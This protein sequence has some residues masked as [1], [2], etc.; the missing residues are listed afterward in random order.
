MSRLDEARAVWLL[1][2]ADAIA[3]WVTYARLPANE[4]YNVTGTGFAGGASRVLVDLNFPVALIA[5]GIALT[6]FERLDRRGRRL[7]AVAIALCAVVV[8]PGVVR[9]SNL[10]ARWINVVPAAGVA[11]VLALTLVAGPAPRRPSSLSSSVSAI[12]IAISATEKL[13]WTSTRLAPAAKPV[14]VTL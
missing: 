9:Q 12:P 4:L 7:G 3:I 14:P 2:L 5:I 6:L 1:V 8:L 13:S 11:L 10:D